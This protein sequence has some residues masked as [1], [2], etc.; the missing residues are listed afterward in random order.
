MND[1]STQPV[2]SLPPGRSG[3]PIVGESIS[4]LRDPARF[5]QQR[6]QQY[7][8]IFKTH[9]FGRPTIALIGADAARFLFANEG[10]RLEMTNTPNFEAL[11]G[12]HSIGVKTG[13]AHQVLRKQLFQAFQPR[14]LAEYTVTMETMT[15]CYLQKWEQMRELTWYPELKQYTLD[16]AY[17]LLVGVDTT[18]DENL[19]TLYETWSNGLLSIPIRFPGSKLDRAMRARERLLQ[20]I[21]TLI[22]QR[23]HNPST[24][25]DALGILLQAQD[26]AGNYLSRADVKDNILALLIAGHETLTSALTSLCLFLAQH[27]DVLQTARA[28][29]AQLG[30][31]GTLTQES[32]KQLSYLE[33]VLKEVLRMAPPVV[34]NGQ[35]KVLETCEFAG[36]VIPKGWDVFY[37]IQETQQDPNVY[38]HSEQFDPQ[39]FAPDRAEDKKVFSHIPFGGGIR[40]CL[41]KEFARL[42]MKLFATLLIRDYDWELLPG[43][44]LERVVLPFS[45]PRDGLKVKF[46]QRQK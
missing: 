29:Q 31:T 24:Q 7:G 22:D 36:F 42:E 25:Q 46:W 14:A 34:R 6:Q 13:S 8:N 1:I 12:V 21:D 38:T 26:E 35:R 32:L 4:Y 20:R 5:I 16:I 44:N 30:L 9:L 28:E 37:Q 15:H 2:G 11:L 43:Q 27:P 3:L 23:Q 45:R 41:G 10:Q 19:G 17:K 18:A 33:Q 39:R 40:E